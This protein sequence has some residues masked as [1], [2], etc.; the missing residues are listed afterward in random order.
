M[1]D[2]ALA[3]IRYGYF[4]N[5]HLGAL[6]RQSPYYSNDIVNLISDSPLPYFMLIWYVY[7]L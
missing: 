3:E 1:M 6:L 7:I 2:K 4:D 5:T